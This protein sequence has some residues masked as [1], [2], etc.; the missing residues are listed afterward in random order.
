M[1]KQN[2]AG[3]EGRK[4]GELLNVWNTFMTLPERMPVF[5]YVYLIMGFVLLIKGADYFVDGASV[6]HNYNFLSFG[7]L[8]QSP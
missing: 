1:H 4:M 8:G 7:V 6:W 2:G 3:I 5:V